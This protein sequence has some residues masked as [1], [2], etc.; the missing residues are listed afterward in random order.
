MISIFGIDGDR[1]TVV[2]DNEKFESGGQLWRTRRPDRRLVRWVNFYLAYQRTAGVAMVRTVA[3]LNSIVVIIDL[4]PAIQRS[5]LGSPLAMVSPVAGMTGE[6][7]AYER[8]EREE[9]VILELTPLGARALFGMPLREL[10]TARAG[11]ADLLG[12][13]A[14]R[15]TEQLWEAESLDHRFRILD[16]WLAERLLDGPTLSKALERSWR[17]LTSSAGSVRIAELADRAGVSRQHLT[18]TFHREI[19]LPPKTVARVARCHWAIRLI[20]GR[21]PPA[22]STVAELCGYTD[23]AHLNRDFRLLVGSTPTGLLSSGASHTDLFLGSE[24]ALRP[25]QRTRT[26]LESGLPLS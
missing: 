21:N 7:I 10:G 5:L 26:P 24:I 20:T 11:M 25:R 15:L 2:Q 19:G 9:G 14:R 13:G 12:A 6:P 1:E 18:T 8:S 22:L 23:Q 4:A 17:A 3:A 16:R